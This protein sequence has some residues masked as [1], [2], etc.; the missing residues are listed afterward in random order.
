MLLPVGLVL[1]VS[2][3][4]ADLKR[5]CFFAWP[6]PDLRETVLAVRRAGRA[7]ASD[8]GRVSLYVCSSSPITGAMP[9]AAFL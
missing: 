2:L 4:C 9:I 5:W 8:L 3:F 6:A 7:S 1:G